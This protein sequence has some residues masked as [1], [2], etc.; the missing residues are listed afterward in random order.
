[1]TEPSAEELYEVHDG[2]PEATRHIIA[3]AVREYR[4]GLGQCRNC[5]RDC[6]CQAAADGM[7]AEVARD[8][9]MEDR[10]DE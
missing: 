10:N 4:A 5:G 1:M 9:A 8:H 3:K 6:D 7:A 2:L